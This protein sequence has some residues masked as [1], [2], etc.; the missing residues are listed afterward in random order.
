MTGIPLSTVYGYVRKDL[1]EHIRRD[2][3]IWIDGPSVRYWT[4]R[5]GGHRPPGVVPRRYRDE[6]GRP[7]EGAD[8][9]PRSELLWGTA[10]ANVERSIAMEFSPLDLDRHH[11]MPGRTEVTETVFGGLRHHFLY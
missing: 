1:V 8:A 2:G 5:R 4:M 6:R 10:G 7:L 11:E 3:R 9:C